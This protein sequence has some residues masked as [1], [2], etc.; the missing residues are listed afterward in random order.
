MSQGVNSFLG[1]L[2]NLAAP[3]ERLR[4][5]QDQLDIIQED[6]VRMDEFSDLFLP[7][8]GWFAERI[9]EHFHG[10]PATQVILDH[11]PPQ[12]R[13]IQIWSHWYTTFFRNRDQDAFLLA[14]WRSGMNHVAAGIDHRY[15]NLAY[16]LARKLIHA[17]AARKLP[18]DVSAESLNLMDRMLDLCL[19]VETDAFITSLTKCDHEII[20]GIAHQVRNPLMVIGG[21]VL[22]LRRQIPAD[23]PKQDIYDTMLLEAN[24]LE[25]MVR[26]VATY[27]EVFQRDP[28]G[29]SCNLESAV[30]TALE[31]LHP[32]ETIR[33]Q[34]EL[35]PEYPNILADPD[36]L[37]A[38]LFHLLQNSLENAV[39][40]DQP[41]VRITSEES[42]HSPR[43]LDIRIF[44]NGPAPDPES[45]ESLFTPF[46]STKALGT[47]FGLPIARLA[48]R[49]NHGHLSLI[50]NQDEG[51]TTLVSLPK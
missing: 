5:F 39:D 15:I 2:P 1:S 30:Q 36:D 9:F 14:Q 26:N 4:S 44:N 21:N 11:G 35:T 48:V 41:L 12:E 16:A 40:A 29:Q 37:R 31:E 6:F 46:Y 20:R 45:L 32:A 25:R 27:N 28:Q 34:T 47:G 7:E 8:K 24:R 51:A 10:I 43:F 18:P 22:R 49:K 13:M 19:L 23:D 38:I 42:T 17:I 33:V 3:M 50:S